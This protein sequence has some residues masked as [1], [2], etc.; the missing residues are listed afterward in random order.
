MNKKQSLNGL[1]KALVVVKNDE[2]KLEVQQIL[3]HVWGQGKWMF[4][5]PT[6]AGREETTCFLGIDSET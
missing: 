2:G 5:P 4:I 6:T 1:A 3:V